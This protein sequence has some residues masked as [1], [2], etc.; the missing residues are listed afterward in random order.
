MILKSYLSSQRLCNFPHEIQPKNVTTF[1]CLTGLHH[2]TSQ[3]GQISGLHRL[4][5]QIGHILKTILAAFSPA[6]RDF[7]NYPLDNWKPL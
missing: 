1:R 4:T 6:C 5:S 3:I 2:L 7:L